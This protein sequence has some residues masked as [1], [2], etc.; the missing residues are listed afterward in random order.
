MG[1]HKSEL[2]DLSESQQEIMEVIWQ[3]GELSARAVTDLISK[4]RMVAKNTI[5]T[6]LERMEQKGWLRHRIEGRTYLYSAARG[7]EETI[8]SKVVELLDQVCGGSPETLMNAL[9][10]H[11][12]LTKS[13]LD[14]VRSLL[15]S[16]KS[17]SRMNK[18]K[19]R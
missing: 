13:E 14:R 5:R 4:R 8:G 11:R 1:T 9:I 18:H 19:R 17:R 7:R 10:S 16:A 6:L 2:P 3:H 12:G 15:A